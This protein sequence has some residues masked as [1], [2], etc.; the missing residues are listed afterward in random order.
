MEQHDLNH[1]F[2]EYRE[3]IHSL[4]MSNGHFARLFDEYHDVNR[5]VVLV[6]I[7]AELATGFE[8]EDLKKRRLKLKDEIHE[9]LKGSS[10]IN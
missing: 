8:L 6:E 7:N 4:K 5:H 2:P 1:E 10:A 9:I 3:Q